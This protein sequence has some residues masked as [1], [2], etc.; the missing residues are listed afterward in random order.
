LYSWLLQLKMILSSGR[1]NSVR[2][3]S[4]ALFNTSLHEWQWV[5]GECRKLKC[6]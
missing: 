1:P 2:R 6:S 5:R 3:G 4:A